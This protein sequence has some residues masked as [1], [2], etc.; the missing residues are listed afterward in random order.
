MY[1][2]FCSHLPNLVGCSHSG[3]LREHQGRTSASFCF[4]ILFLFLDYFF[5]SS[6]KKGTGQRPPQACSRL[7]V[8]VTLARVCF[9]RIVRFLTVK[10][11]CFNLLVYFPAL[12][13]DRYWLLMLFARE[14]DR[15]RL[16][17]ARPRRS[18]VSHIV[19]HNEYISRMCLWLVCWFVG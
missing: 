15:G 16:A 17:I 14:G 18:H 11:C 9:G 13:G 4:F 6:R 5:P 2:Q 1:S 19:S 8:A 7:S 10:V 12:S 3:H